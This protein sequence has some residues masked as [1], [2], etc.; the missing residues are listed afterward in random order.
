MEISAHV[1]EIQQN[2]RDRISGKTIKKILPWRVAFVLVA[3]HTDLV[4]CRTLPS[5]SQNLCKLS[6]KPENKKNYS[7]SLAARCFNI[8]IWTIQR[9]GN[10]G[11]FRESWVKKE[12]FSSAY[13]T[14]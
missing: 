14:K 4:F 3:S 6:I 13:K 10:E 9:G 12:D 11:K 7:Y 5:L 2:S 8:T 1:K